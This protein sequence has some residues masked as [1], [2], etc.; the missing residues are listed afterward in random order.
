MQFSVVRADIVNV[1]A[2]AIVLPA[3]ERLKEGSGTSKALFEAAGR[4]ELTRACEKIGHCDMGCAVP[5]LAFNLNAIYIVHTVVPR[6]VDGQSNEYDLLSS[7]YLAALNL[8]DVLRCN[9]IAF[10]ILASGYN[11]F[12]R[13]LAVHIAEETISRFIGTNLTKVTLVVYGDSMEE[14]M[15]SLGFMVE[16]IPEHVTMEKKNAEKE[17]KAKLIAEGK[18]IAQKLIEE[19]LDWLKDEKNR[20]KIYEVGGMIAAAVTSMVKKSS[21]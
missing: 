5:T 16:S 15:K 17:K 3:D 11:G 12:D 8:A 13:E 10:P 21:K 20:K 6:W 1:V 9:S 18:D 7:A 4:K 14:Y 19:A 2:D